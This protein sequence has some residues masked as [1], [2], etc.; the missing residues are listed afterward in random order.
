MAISED[1]KFILSGSGKGEIRM[2]DALSGEAIGLSLRG[3]KSEIFVVAIGGEG[4]LI[5]SGH[6]DGTVR[7]WDISGRGN[8]S[9]ENG[10][11]EAFDNTP[12]IKCVTI[13]AD[14]NLAVPSSGKGVVQKWDVSTGEAVG[15]HMKRGEFLQCVAIIKNGT[16]IV[17]VAYSGTVQRWDASTGE[18]IG[19]PVYGHS[20]RV[21]AIVISDDGKLIVTGS[22]DTTVRQ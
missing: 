16:L 4:K 18:S 14:G 15:S 11:L 17:S 1:D 12:C 9:E 13:S 19:E 5:W 2:W 20:F 8:V 6:E 3:S 21:G 10:S 22:D 7:R